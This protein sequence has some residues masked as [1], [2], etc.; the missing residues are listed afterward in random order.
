MSFWKG[1]IFNEFTEKC[2]NLI[3]FHILTILVIYL[4]ISTAFPPSFT[5][6]P[7][8]LPLYFGHWLRTSVTHEWL[9]LSS[10]KVELCGRDN[11][12]FI[13]VV[14]LS[15]LGRILLFHLLSFITPHPI[16]W[17]H[18]W[19]REWVGTWKE[20]WRLLINQL[21]AHC[22]AL[23]LYFINCESSMGGEN[24]S[25]LYGGTTYP[26]GLKLPTHLSSFLLAKTKKSFFF[27]YASSLFWIPCRYDSLCLVSFLPFQSFC[28]P[29]TLLV[30]VLDIYVRRSLI[31]MS[32]ECRGL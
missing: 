27:L 22:W 13:W 4:V 31:S 9:R 3:G 20:G 30:S 18:Y 8:F 5:C 17:F 21:D 16:L 14:E 29:W 1:I 26:L 19:V 11:S 32:S 7:F 24:N 2:K 25:I 23:L 15:L 6:L 10:Q 28:S 12:N